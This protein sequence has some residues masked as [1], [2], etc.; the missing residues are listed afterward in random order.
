MQS[1]VKFVSFLRGIACGSAALL[2]ASA[3]AQDGTGQTVITAARYVDVLAGKTVEQNGAI[4]SSTSVVLNGRI[5]LQASY[6]AVTNTGYDPVLLVVMAE[7]HEPRAHPPPNAL[8]PFVEQGV[9]EPPVGGKRGGQRHGGGS[10]GHGP[11]SIGPRCGR[12]RRRYTPS[13]IRNS[14]ITPDGRTATATWRGK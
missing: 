1:R 13:P 8:D 11:A 7:D 5:D 2:S 12:V 6:G 10:G 9:I 4:N 3:V 14:C